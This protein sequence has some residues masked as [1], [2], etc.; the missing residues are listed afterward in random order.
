M[1]P[2]KNHSEEQYNKTIGFLEDYAL[3]LGAELVCIKKEKFTT[4]SGNNTIV[5]EVEM[6]I[7]K[8]G[9]EYYWLEDHFLPDCPFIVFSFGD[10]IETIFEDAD[11]FPYNLSEDELKAEVRYSLGI[12]KYPN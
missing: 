10:T 9:S 6:K 2:Y 7:F 1:W 4:I 5:K 8:F 3:S 12:E 11:P